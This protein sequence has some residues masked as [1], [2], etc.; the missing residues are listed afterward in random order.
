MALPEVLGEELVDQIVR[1]VLDHL[2]LFEDHLLLA[3]DVVGGERRAH[4]DVGQHVDR[5][6]QVLVEHLDVVAGVLLRR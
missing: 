4:H 5:Q 3:L 6:R 2:D 1:R